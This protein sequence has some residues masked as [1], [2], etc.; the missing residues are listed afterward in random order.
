[1]LR[2]LHFDIISIFYAALSLHATLCSVLCV[3]PGQQ[4]QLREAEAMQQALG[5]QIAGLRAEADQGAA[6]YILAKVCLIPA[7]ALVHLSDNI[8]T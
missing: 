2:C 3:G 4:R 5:Q 6:N 8:E 7:A 1:M